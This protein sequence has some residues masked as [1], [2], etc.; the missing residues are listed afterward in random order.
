MQNFIQPLRLTDCD[1]VLPILCTAITC[2]RLDL[3][4][5]W[6]KVVWP[7]VYHFDLSYQPEKFR[8]LF[9][10]KKGVKAQRGQTV[11]KD[12]V[13]LSADVSAW[14]EWLINQMG[15]MGSCS[16]RKEKDQ[17]KQTCR[18]LKSVLIRLDTFTQSVSLVYLCKLQHT[19]LHSCLMVDLHLCD[20]EKCTLLLLC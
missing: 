18:S 7:R 16:V 10:V 12:V 11:S 13:E 14:T 6:K 3:S 5:A 17:L 4:L 9:L 20:S 2:E 15:Q 1:P 19:L 8:F